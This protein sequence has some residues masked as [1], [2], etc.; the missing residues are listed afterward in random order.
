M[1]VKSV[2]KTQAEIER[3]VEITRE[4]GAFG[5]DDT[6]VTQDPAFLDRYGLA[7]AEFEK[8]GIYDAQGLNYWTQ[9]YQPNT[10]VIQN[11]D[12]SYTETLKPQSLRGDSVTAYDKG[13]LARAAIDIEGGTDA[14]KKLAKDNLGKLEVEWGRFL[15][16]E[17]KYFSKDVFAANFKDHCAN[18]QWENAGM[19][20]GK[21]AAKFSDAELKSL[22]VMSRWLYFANLHGIT[23]GERS[24]LSE[25]LASGSYSGSVGP[26]IALT[27]HMLKLAGEYSC[28]VVFLPDFITIGIDTSQ[29]TVYLDP[30]RVNSTKRENNIGFMPPDYFDKRPVGKMRRLG[31]PSAQPWQILSDSY[32]VTGMKY[33]E[34]EEYQSARTEFESA[35]EICPENQNALVN[36]AKTLYEL[37]DTQAAIECLNDVLAL[38]EEYTDAKNLLIKYDPLGELKRRF[39]SN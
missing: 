3:L 38:N 26:R 13:D 18:V 25:V 20:P 30:G 16:D 12:G 23:A 6:T 32:N 7:S 21:V 37:G 11:A 19:V 33:F 34:A 29:G 31:E 22:F 1:A 5:I 17:L 10:E 28:N 24:S 15:K 9:E 14:K 39:T 36:L 4:A 27:L 8:W 35:L 2:V